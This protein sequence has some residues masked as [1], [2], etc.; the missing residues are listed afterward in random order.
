MF[1]LV[2][3]F[4]RQVLLAGG[5]AT[6]LGA[7]YVAMN[8]GDA[9]NSAINSLSPTQQPDPSAQQPAALLSDPQAG[10]SHAGSAAPRLEGQP[11]ENLL[12]VF[13]FDISP[14]WVHQ[15]WSRKST[16]LSDLEYHGI[17]IPLVTGTRLHD[18][19]GA[20]TYYF[21]HQ[22][23]L[24]RITFRGTTGDPRRLIAMLVGSY[25]FRPQQ[26]HSPGE[27]LYEVTWNRRA[28][29]RLLCRPQATIQATQP[30]TAYDVQLHLER[31]GAARFL[32]D[33]SSVTTLPESSGS[34]R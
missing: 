8:P 11:V 9:V 27:L 3:R 25:G 33:A 10:L 26:P 17:R 7:P 34:R 32:D 28:I 21:N 12:E 14:L 15:R 13:R 16:A 5:L 6:A 23:R 24:E 31:P 22:G 20:L 29:S 30:Y 2:G 1:D 18:L 19:A 4:R